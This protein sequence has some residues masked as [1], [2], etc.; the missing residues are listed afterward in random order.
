MTTLRVMS[1]NINQIQRQYEKLCTKIRLLNDSYYNK[2][3]SLVSDAEYDALFKELRELEAKYPE[4]D[5][6]NSPTRKVGAVVQSELGKV[7]HEVPMLSLDNAFNLDDLKAFD[8][9]VKNFLKIDEAEAIDYFA[10]PK[11]DGLSFSAVYENGKLSLGATR[12]DGTVGE[13]I[14]ENLKQVINMPLEVA[15]R[16][17]F[18][19]RGEVYISNAD[20]EALNESSAKKFANPRNAAAG[21]LRQLDTSITA[22]RKLR[23]FAYAL[24]GFDEL[25]KHSLKIEKLEELGFSTN[26][27]WN[28]VIG[29]RH[30]GVGI[31]GVEEYYSEL[32]N[33]RPNLGYDIDGI[34]YKVDSIGLQERLGFVSRSPRWAIAQKFPAEKAITILNDIT[35]QV[36]RTGSLTPVA[37]LEAI[38][39]GGV[40]VKRATLHNKDE[41][42]RLG[43]S[44][45]DKIEIQRAGD[46][47]PQVLKV[48][49]KGAGDDFEFPNQCPV[50]SAVVEQEEGE[51][52]LRCTN[53]L[54]CEAQM[55]GWLKHFISRKAFDI[56]GFGQAQIDLFWILDLVKK[57]SDIFNLNNHGAMLMGQE[58]YG[59][60]SVNNLFE[61]VEK[62]VTQ[63]LDRFIYALG[64]RF[65]GTENAKL[66]A[67]YFTSI[68]G[69]IKFIKDKQGVESLI[70]IDGLGEKVL[71][72][73]LELD[74]F[75]I[76]EIIKL[77]EMLEVSDFISAKG[78][79]MLSGKSVV[80]TGTLTN[81]SR[82]EAKAKA[83]GLGASVKG[84]ISKAIDM[85]IY[86]E[87][88]GSKLKKAEELGIET[89][90]EQE[91]LDFIAS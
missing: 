65:I 82:A 81:L 26:E 74:E 17:K 88:A 37:E 86:G 61:G 45:G 15:E 50:C 56:N 80:F 69:F 34:V 38:N 6:E 77:S 59:E 2:S 91:W 41:I 1:N 89:M 83:E 20:F 9:K 35:I 32:Y 12:G 79:G 58:G 16:R 68:N 85:L 11:I 84:S 25:Q 66:L 40:V 7:T 19:I 30:K 44:V 53:G 71:S 33:S 55:K 36:G 72:Q 3:L 28:K 62:A 18:E 49:E 75:L 54:N 73:L 47:I 60:L 29:I 48:V 90:S 14:T 42:A 23:Y 4:L 10:E 39:I 63:P 31:S 5:N 22:S 46:V 78:E 87:K 13:N 76:E 70:N 21:S 52:A 51:V 43:I 67:E 8:K 27:E 64:I 24:H 57:P